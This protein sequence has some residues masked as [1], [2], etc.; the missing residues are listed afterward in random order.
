M[1]PCQRLQHV[2]HHR[3][4]PSQIHYGYQPKQTVKKFV[5]GGTWGH[6]EIDKRQKV[7]PCKDIIH[8]IFK[9]GEMGSSG[10]SIRSG[11]RIRHLT[12]NINLLTF[13]ITKRTWTGVLVGCFKMD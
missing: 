3:R 4:A 1:L 8:V 9:G 6:Y 10:A 7:E 13:F 2:L 5:T 11:F 12:F